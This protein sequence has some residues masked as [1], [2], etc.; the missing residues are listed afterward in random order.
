[1]L[2]IVFHSLIIVFL[3]LF[4]QLGGIAWLIALLFRRRIPVFVTAYVALALG[5]LWVAPMLGRVPL[6]CL[7][8]EALRVQSPVFCALNRQYVT[9]ELRDVLTDYAE[10]MAQAHPGTQTRILDANFPFVAGFPLLPH[11]SHNDGRKVDLAFY[12]TDTEGYL[13]GTARSRLGYFAF[14]DG[15]T[16]CPAV[17]LSLR[18]NMVWLQGLWPE[19]ALDDT[20]MKTGLELLSADSRVSKIFIEPNLKARFAPDSSKIRFQGCRAARH[21]DHIHF[22]L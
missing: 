1:M 7:T 22:Q 12:Y 16:D 9:P 17:T 19:Y 14:E 13:A 5:A 6:P 20:R 21:D 3:T 8:G 11:L 10:A 18:W 4:S 15:P 2:R